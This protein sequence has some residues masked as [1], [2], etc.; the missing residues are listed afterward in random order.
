LKKTY[1]GVDISSQMI[2]TARQMYGED[3]NTEFLV[4]DVPSTSATTV[5]ASGIFNLQLGISKEDWIALS[6]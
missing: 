5:V 6:K 3:N 4:D 1:I 2:E